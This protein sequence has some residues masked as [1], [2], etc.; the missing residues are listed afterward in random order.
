MLRLEVNAASPCRLDRYLK[1]LYP[2]LTQGIIE[3]SLR[4]KKIMVNACKV[5]ASVRITVGDKIFLDA[6]LHLNPQKATSKNFSDSAIILAG[7]L[8]KDYLIYQDNYLIAINK[9]EGIATQGGS[10]ISLSIDDALQYLNSR[11]GEFKLVHR[12]DKD[13][14]GILLIAKNYSS[15]IKLVKS[16]QEKIIQKTYIAVVLGNLTKNEGQIVGMIGKNRDGVY[17]TVQDDPANGKLAITSYRLLE[18]L[19]LSS[20]SN[21]KISLIE[22]VPL[23]GRMHQLRFHAKMLNCPIIGDKKYGSLEAI[24]LS[25]EMLLHAKKVVLP[26]QIF[27]KE[28]IMEAELPHYFNNVNKIP[29]K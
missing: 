8:L 11:G 13:T 16:F 4:H 14:S 12:L 24:A 28:I 7:K 23:T 21:L 27:G 18:V 20:I 3:R 22:F 9:P 10:K 19:G 2:G 15:S 5:E 6:A 29:K 26:E 1:R 17:E 25:K